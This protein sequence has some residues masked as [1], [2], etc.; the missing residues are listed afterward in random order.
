MVQGIRLAWN[1]EVASA[2]AFL[3]PLQFSL[4]QP[5]LHVMQA[6][7]VPHPSPWQRPALL[8]Q[9]TLASP[10]HR[11]AL[12]QPTPLASRWHCQSLSFQP[13]LTS[14]SQA[15]PP[16]SPALVPTQTRAGR[17]A[18]TNATYRRL[19]SPQRSPARCA[20]PTR[21]DRCWRQEQPAA[22]LERPPSSHPRRYPVQI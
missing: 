18:S 2:W 21:S 20:S 16:E 9:L 7:L 4:P 8:I 3:A 1:E 10:W 11:P 12:S 5:C 13:T 15:G 14:P 17:R 6:S 22:R 19:P